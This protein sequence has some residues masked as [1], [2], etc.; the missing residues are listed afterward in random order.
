MS[1]CHGS[2][3]KS[4]AEFRYTLDLELPQE[5]IETVRDLSY[6]INPGQ[7]RDKRS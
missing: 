6:A 7:I 3:G 1:K 2:S 5:L 4:S